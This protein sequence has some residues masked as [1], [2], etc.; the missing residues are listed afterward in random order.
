MPGPA[1]I[2]EWATWTFDPDEWRLT[3][4]DAGVVS[5]HN[6]SLELLA[7]LLERAPALVSKDEILATV[8]RDAAVEEGNIAFHVAM[9]RK[10]LDAPGSE[11]SCI[12]TVRARGYRF[13]TP[14]TR[15]TARTGLVTESREAALQPA[16]EPFRPSVVEAAAPAPQRPSAL[17]PRLTTRQAA[18]LLPG[19]LL[20]IAAVVVGWFAM[21]GLRPRIGDVAVMSPRIDGEVAWSSRAPALVASLLA[22]ALPGVRTGTWQGPDETVREAGRRL[23]ADAV[24]ATAIDRSREPWRAEV[25]LVRTRDQRRLWNWV[26]ELLPSDAPDALMASRIASGLR[27]HLGLAASGSSVGEAESLVL[28]ARQNWRLRNPHSVAEAITLYE[29]AIAIDPSLARAHAGLADCYNLTMSGL[30]TAVRYARAKASVE[31]AL[32]LDP[33]LA[34]AL[35]A[36]AFLFYKFESRWEEADASFRQ[37]IAADPEYA[38]ARH[39]HGEFLGMMGRYDEAIARLQEALTLDPGSLAIQGDLVPPLLRARRVAEARAVV[40][41]AAVANPNWFWVPRRRAEVLAAEGRERES[42]EELWRSMVLNGES[43]ESVEGLRAAYRAGGMAAVLRLESQRLEAAE[44]AGP[45]AGQRATFLSFNYARLGEPDTAMRWIRVA[46]D[47]REDAAIHL[48]TNPAYDSLRDRP[49]FHQQLAA[50]G[51]TALPR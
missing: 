45:G 22:P 40:E 6:K 32:A 31:R 49:D 46:V 48:L 10:A 34:E 37:A 16:S 29:R 25:Q 47:R 11:S 51:L 36:Q 28:Q 42:L 18:A 43:L 12:Q 44:A 27:G 3:R 9:L 38:L 4:A 14:V 24:L 17:Q 21:T 2:F 26:F 13:V 41:R 8:W 50:L 23:S 7:L 19:A 5:L 35:T 20:L 15:R 33:N 30:P 1:P 39:W